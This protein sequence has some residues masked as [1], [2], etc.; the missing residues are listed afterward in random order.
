LSIVAGFEFNAASR[1]TELADALDSTVMPGKYSA[2]AGWLPSSTHLV[3][4]LKIAL[5]SLFDY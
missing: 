2:V 4:V 1:V 5:E 3:L